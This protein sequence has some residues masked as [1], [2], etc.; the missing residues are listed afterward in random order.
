[1]SRADRR[2]AKRGCEAHAG[3][4]GFGE[5]DARSRAAGADEVE[6]SGR[7]ICDLGP[8]TTDFGLCPTQGDRRALGAMRRVVQLSGTIGGLQPCHSVI[9]ICSPRSLHSAVLPETPVTPVTTLP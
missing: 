4:D 2:D 7:R 9:A 8:L 6:T 1:M 5:K 3:A